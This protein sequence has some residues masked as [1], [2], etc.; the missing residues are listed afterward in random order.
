MRAYSSSCMSQSR[1]WLVCHGCVC[2]YTCLPKVDVIHRVK[3]Y[4]TF[5]PLQSKWP[6]H[7]VLHNDCGSHSTQTCCLFGNLQVN[8]A[9]V[10]TIALDCAL[11]W[12]QTLTP[13]YMHAG[14]N[15]SYLR[16]VKS[17]SYDKVSDSVVILRCVLACL[18]P[19]SLR[20][21]YCLV[22]Y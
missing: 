15:G 22:S 12:E 3:C 4:Q 2:V 10:S 9:I 21:V 1:W 16:V 7:A 8:E 11:E 14:N 17:I 5:W 13:L 19:G 20:C 6:H 18:V